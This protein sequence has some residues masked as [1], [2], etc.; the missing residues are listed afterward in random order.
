MVAILTWGRDL[1]IQPIDS[2]QAVHDLKRRLSGNGA[3]REFIIHDSNLLCPVKLDNAVRQLDEEEQ[4]EWLMTEA[5]PAL[6]K[7][8]KM[9]KNRFDKYVRATVEV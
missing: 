9:E 1:I 3:E 5:Y 8:G 7:E 2:I 6:V 4:I